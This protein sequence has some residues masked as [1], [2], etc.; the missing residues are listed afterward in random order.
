MT[1]RARVVELLLQA[2]Y[3]AN[4]N[5]Q[6]A[7]NH[8]PE[9]V[10]HTPLI[11]A[12]LLGD[13]PIAKLL[14]QHGANLSTAD[15]TG[16]TALIAAASLG[17]IELVDTLLFFASSF[18]STTTTT[19]A[20]SDGAS[21]IEF[22]E[23]QEQQQPSENQQQ[24][25]D[26]KR[27]CQQ[28]DERGNTALHYAVEGKYA[29]I[30]EAL[31]AAGAD[32][33]Q[34]NHAGHSALYLAHQKSDGAHLTAV[35][36][37][38]SSSMDLGH[39]YNVTSGEDSSYST[40]QEDAD[41]AA[42]DVDVDGDPTHTAAGTN[43][44]YAAG[45][46]YNTVDSKHDVGSDYYSSSDGSG[47]SD[48]IDEDGYLDVDKLY[49]DLLNDASAPSS[50]VNGIDGDLLDCDMEC[51]CC[52]AIEGREADGIDDWTH[53][54]GRVPGEP[55][56]PT[57]SS[58]FTNTPGETNTINSASSS[59][60]FTKKEDKLPGLENRD[61]SDYQGKE[62]T[63]SGAA[64]GINSKITDTGVVGGGKD[65]G[66]FNSKN[67]NEPNSL[68][69][70]EIIKRL[71]MELARKEEALNIAL[72]QQHR[73]VE[74]DHGSQLNRRRPGASAMDSAG[75]S[76]SGTT[77]HSNSHTSSIS[78]MIFGRRTSTS[79]GTNINTANITTGTNTSG[80]ALPV[81]AATI[82]VILFFFFFQRRLRRSQQ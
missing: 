49:T 25:I 38:Q 80:I 47:Y 34:G 71:E 54:S 73:A 56:L 78:S 45:D 12:T 65:T 36:L 46:P 48:F 26:R 76:S 77:S 21:S 17:N 29:L 1:R 7:A 13:T 66:N 59:S 39:K 32:I 57:S 6:S 50:G 22:A 8:T 9:D 24:Q 52:S 51:D 30:V 40:S 10:D 42:Y 28:A 58:S 67:G 81:L 4:P 35:L 15:K 61:E 37:Q 16:T 23:D 19:T 44:D 55:P 27:L 53:L 72:Q 14:V 74:G 31:V 60:R 33:H 41:A 2:P 3:H 69:P 11:E 43:N 62:W 5:T 82:V 75:A 63:G 20:A 79:T 68:P 70:H 64:E 18:S